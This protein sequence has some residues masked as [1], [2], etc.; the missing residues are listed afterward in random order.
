[1][2]VWDALLEDRGRLPP[3]M[4]LRLEPPDLELTGRPSS[5][6]AVEAPSSPS[7]LPIWRA[8]GDAPPPVDPEAPVGGRGAGSISRSSGSGS[9]GTK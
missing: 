7:E 2:V 9:S 5:A 8:E 6:T 4:A 1:M 3:L